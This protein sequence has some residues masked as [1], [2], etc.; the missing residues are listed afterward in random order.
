[1]LLASVPALVMDG[2]AAQQ[3]QQPGCGSQVEYER[4][5][6]QVATN[7][8]DQFGQ[9]DN[10]AGGMPSECDTRC[11]AV[12]SVF[13][14]ACQDYLTTSLNSPGVRQQLVATHGKCHATEQANLVHD[15]DLI[16]PGEQ[17]DMSAKLAVPV[18]CHAMQLKTAEELNENTGPMDS[19]WMIGVKGET[20][21]MY[22]KGQD[23]VGGYTTQEEHDNC[24]A[25]VNKQRVQDLMVARYGEC[26]EH[27]PS[28]P[29]PGELGQ[30]LV[31]VHVDVV[32]SGGVKGHTTYQ[33]SLKCS[34]QTDADGN[35]HCGI[36][37][38][39]A[40]YGSP[41]VTT[42]PNAG[43]AAHGMEF[44]AA[45]QE[46]TPFGANVGGSNPAF[47]AISPSA[48]YDS[49][50][51]VAETTGATESVSSIGI[52]FDSWTDELGLVIDNGA[53]FWMDPNAAPSVDPANPDAWQ[54]VLAQVTVEDGVAWSATINVRG[55]LAGYED[56]GGDDW[57]ATRLVPSPGNISM[58]CQSQTGWSPC[59]ERLFEG[60][61]QNR[62]CDFVADPDSR[63][64]SR[65]YTNVARSRYL[66]TRMFQSGRVAMARV[67][68]KTVT[69]GSNGGG[70]RR[71]RWAPLRTWRQAPVGWLT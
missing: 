10:C 64:F 71:S 52:D 60:V 42:G 26:V 4:W 49:W 13:Y 35:D 2:A 67:Q 14:A 55:K 25:L 1:M 50:L 24:P 36:D 29:P 70:E 46:A 53:V 19:L 31:Q 41:A 54:C 45:Y 32:S 43:E 6:G 20:S 15:T 61:S 40:M 65:F 21:C 48:Q 8:C 51:A 66:A 7:C 28:P 5:L 27:R 37:N 18:N 63:S 11:A 22:R 38:L 30:S 57:E 69:D 68:L 3:P 12:Y 62:F 17:H 56:N 9:E 33:L 16:T 23:T 58:T 39:Y 47:W 44:P 34:I 59:S